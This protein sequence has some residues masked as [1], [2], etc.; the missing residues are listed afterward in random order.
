LSRNDMRQDFVEDLYSSDAFAINLEENLRELGNRIL[1]DTY[2]PGALLRIEVPKG[3]L[4]TRPGSVPLMRD[5]VAL[6]SIIYLIGPVADKLIPPNVYS[7]RVKKDFEPQKGMFHETDTLDIPFVKRQQI[8]RE[9]DPFDPWY[10]AWPEFDR[11]SRET[12]EA[13]D[14]RFMA[15]SDIS[16]YFEN[17]QL[18]MLRDTLHRAVPNEHRIVSLLLSSLEAWTYKTH[19][20]RQQLRGIPQGT[21]ISSFL[22]NLFL[23]SLD[24]V[25]VDFER[26]TGSKYFRYMDDIRVFAKSVKDARRAIFRL[27]ATL[28]A[29]HLNMQSAKTRIYDENAKEITFALVDSRVDYLKTLSDQ[30]RT[31]DANHKLS[32]RRRTQYRDRLRRVARE[33]PSNRREQRI[34]G[35]RRKLEG[36]SLRVF[37]LWMTAHLQLGLS[38]FVPALLAELRDNPDNR[39]TR[40][41]VASAKA[42]PRRSSIATSVFEFVE[43]DLNIFAH[44]EAE[45]LR[46]CRYL[47]VI[48]AEL[49]GHARRRLND[50]SQHYYVRMQSA[51]LLSR[52]ELSSADLNEL[53]RL[54]NVERNSYVQA[55]VTTLLVQRS[56]VEHLQ[57]IER[58]V[59]HPNLRV[60][61]NGRLFIAL[62]NDISVARQRMRFVFDEAVPSRL[63]DYMAFIWVLASS[64]RIETLRTLADMLLPVSKA[65]RITGLRGV[66]ARIRQIVLAR[67]GTGETE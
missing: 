55:A 21:T 23:L 45:L 34:V 48:P 20:G 49:L 7:F 25:F 54:F 39:L 27:D 1:T 5:R 42:F 66:L 58:F 19:T 50:E 4:G 40:R 35:R 13:E 53:A 16:A 6:Y 32:R 9:I 37:R 33:N 26:E 56:G 62:S 2:R 64:P 10:A 63:A 47:A 61:D 22:G 11:E 28:R 14:Y 30:I 24:E 44:Q 15:T 3:S 17:I 41:L 59:C 29:L 38:D 43:S 46:A 51:F 18:G 57:W 36:L 31:D 52:T 60:R 8:V 67:L 12:F 65:I